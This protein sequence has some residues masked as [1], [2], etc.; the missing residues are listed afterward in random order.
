MA[1]SAHSAVR[2]CHVRSRADPVLAV[3]GRRRDLGDLVLRIHPRQQ[4]V[5]DHWHARHGYR[6]ADLVRRTAAISSSARSMPLGYWVSVT[7]LTPARPAG[8]PVQHAASGCC[9]TCCWV[10][11]SSTTRPGVAAGAALRNAKQNS[12]RLRTFQP[13][14]P[15]CRSCVRLSPGG[16]RIVDGLRPAA[17]ANLGA[18]PLTQH[19]RN[20][21]QFYL[22]APSPCPYLAGHGGTQGL[23]PS[24]R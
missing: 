23:H 7:M 13:T 9:T 17:A 12:L 18:L 11:W 8:R 16:E 10:P 20:T 24:G 3:A 19:S 15:L 4:R 22:T 14:F 2:H 5:G 6:N 21:P 1:A